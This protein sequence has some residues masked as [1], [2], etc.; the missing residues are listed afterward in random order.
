MFDR[1]GA[2]HEVSV[3]YRGTRDLIFKIGNIFVDRV[4][5]PTADSWRQTD[6]G[7]DFQAGHAPNPISPLSSGH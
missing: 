3:G 4:A 2:A 1:L 7:D 6:V 5:E